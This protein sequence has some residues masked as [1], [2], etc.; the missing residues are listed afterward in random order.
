MRLGPVVS[1]HQQSPF[2]LS[3]WN[4]VVTH[5]ISEECRAPAG[6]YSTQTLSAVNLTPSFKVALVQSGIYL[7]TA[8]DKIQRR[9]GRMR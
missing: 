9:D 4:T 7:E 1:G 8:F 3:G 2:R 6:E 5:G